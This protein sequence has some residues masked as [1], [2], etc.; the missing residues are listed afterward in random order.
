MED[1]A[2]RFK[3]RPISNQ[4]TLIANAVDY[5]Y[6][7]AESPELRHVLMEASTGLRKAEKAINSLVKEEKEE[8]A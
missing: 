2:I 1:S 5:Y 8:A 7:V 3:L 4:L 6:T